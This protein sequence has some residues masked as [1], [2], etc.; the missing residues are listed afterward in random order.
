[1]RLLLDTHAFLWFLLDDPG[2]S[3]TA[4][5]LI[6]DPGNDI[7]ISPASY[8]EIA[9]KIGLGKYSLPEPYDTF[10]ERELAENDFRILPILPRH[11]SVLTTLPLHHR[12][13]FDRLLVAQAISEG[14]SLVSND[15]ALDVYSIQR[16]W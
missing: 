7:E 6:V 15:P 1:M 11:T 14:I 4:R 10:M 8:W 16:L 12:D 5:N 13:P 3:E 2:L 9:I